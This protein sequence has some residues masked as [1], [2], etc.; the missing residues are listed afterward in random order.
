MGMPSISAKT[1][2]KS[3]AYPYW[4]KMSSATGIG[5]CPTTKEIASIG[6]QGIEND[7]R[8]I[9]QKDSAL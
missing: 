1:Q 2:R 9:L 5:G 8:E 4:M 3:I 7:A 6:C